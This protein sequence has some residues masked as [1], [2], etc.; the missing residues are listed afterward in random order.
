MSLFEG[1]KISLSPEQKKLFY[2]LCDEARTIF[3]KGVRRFDPKAFVSKS[4]LPD[5]PLGA[6]Q[7]Y[8]IY[9]EAFLI[10][11]ARE[12][13]KNITVY[14]SMEE[15]EKIML[16]KMLDIMTEHLYDS[17]SI[18]LLCSAL[19]Y[20][21]TYLSTL[22]KKHR[23]VSL[24]HYYNALKIKEAKKLLSSHSVS[25]TAYRLSFNTPYYFTKVFKKYEGLSPSE[26]KK[27]HTPA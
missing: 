25:E 4:L 11:C 15:F 26:Y 5:A 19:N 9:L 24:M 7:L 20:S 6:Q 27:K 1:L 22:F 14:D 21:K 8:R 13:E 18:N 3:Q 16:E 10:L 17:F 23:G 2:K 12:K